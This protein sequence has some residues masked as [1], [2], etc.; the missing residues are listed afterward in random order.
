MCIYYDRNSQRWWQESGG[1]GSWE[2]GDLAWTPGHCGKDLCT[3]SKHSTNE[4]TGMPD[5][6]SFKHGNNNE[7]RLKCSFE[8]WE[9]SS[10]SKDR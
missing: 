3:W 8:G 4:A 7:P 1:K 10:A 2:G 9:H 5:K 6:I